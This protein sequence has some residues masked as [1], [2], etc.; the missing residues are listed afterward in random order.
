MWKSLFLSKV[1][2]LCF[3][4][5]CYPLVRWHLF[6]SKFLQTALGEHVQTFQQPELHGRQRWREENIYAVLLTSKCYFLP[7][8]ESKNVWRCKGAL[9]FLELLKRD[10]LKVRLKFLHVLR[11][12]LALKVLEKS[13][14]NQFF[15]LFSSFLR[16]VITF[17]GWRH[18]LFGY[19]IPR[20]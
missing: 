13:R 2:K 9:S 20:Q 3:T 5:I 16:S 12:V 7:F 8:S 4:V 19:K 18:L 17:A 15:P 10:P 11:R 14:I 6:V 1:C